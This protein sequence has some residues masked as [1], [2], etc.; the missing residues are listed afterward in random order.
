MCHKCFEKP[1]VKHEFKLKKEFPLDYMALWILIRTD[2]GMTKGKI[3]A[4]TAHA[5]LGVYKDLS[6]PDDFKP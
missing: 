6:N 2:L 4:Q 3:C 5:V 1:V